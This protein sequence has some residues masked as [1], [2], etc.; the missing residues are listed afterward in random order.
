MPDLFAVGDE[1]LTFCDF[2]ELI[3][4]A[5]RLLSERAFAQRLGD[6]ASRRAHHDHTYDLRVA[7]IMETVA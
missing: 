1:V 7:A 5:T 4:Q 3:D 6:A 2:D